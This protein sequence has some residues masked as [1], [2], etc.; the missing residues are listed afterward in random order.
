VALADERMYAAKNRGGRSALS[1]SADVL[2]RLLAERDPALSTHLGEVSD[3]A[4]A[5][6]RRVGLPADEVAQVERA[7]EL[8]DVGKAA[9]PDEILNKPA[10]LDDYE[11]AFMRRHTIIGERIL[12]AAPALAEVARIVRSTHEHVDGSGYPDGLTGDDILLGAR[13]ITVCD[14]FDA[15]IAERPYRAPM[16]VPDAVAELRRCAGSQ[17]DAAVVGAFCAELD[18]RGGR[19]P[20]PAPAGPVLLS[21]AP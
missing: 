14:S 8:H 16:T 20:A 7:A 10:K 5:V 12:V 19:P 2:M 11:W 18:A 1:Q 17:F 4:G 21:P 15:M 3:L 9:I 13:I 6:A